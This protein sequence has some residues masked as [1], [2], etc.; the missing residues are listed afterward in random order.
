MNG[1]KIYTKLFTFF[2]SKFL[3]LLTFGIAKLAVY[4]APLWLA[5][6]LSK[7]DYGVLEYALAGLG[8]LIAASFSL[9]IPGAYPYFILRKKNFKVKHAFKIHPLWLLFLFVINQILYI[10]FEVFS[11]K[12][13]L[14][15]NFSYIIANQQFYSTKLKSKESI[16][17]AVFIDSGVYFMLLI[18]ATL[19]LL[20]IIKPTIEM[21]NKTIL[22]YAFIY[23]LYAMAQF[24]KVNKE[25]IISSYKR[26]LKFSFH[27]L[28]ASILIFAI[29]VAGRILTE[30]FLG[31]EYV[32]TY[33]FYYRLASLVVVIHQV[34]SIIFFKKIYTF[35]PKILDKY[36]SL[37]FIGIYILSILFYFISPYVVVYFSNYYNETFKENTILYFI[38]SS[39][40]VMWIAS[41]L[42]SSIIDREGIAKKN[43]LR[44]LTLIIISLLILFLLKNYLTL[45][46]LTFIHFT[47]FYIATMIQY[48]SLSK[49][50]IYFKKATIALTC[51][52]TIS[53]LVV[54]LIK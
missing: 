9:G 7:Y 16:L 36:F 21:V 20:N 46:L 53:V 47:V 3:F 38:L 43:N 8:I 29:T 17:K 6:I 4:L 52:F 42:N 54:L 40:M 11:F 27:I 23:V 48:F 34:V 25:G 39:Q 45:P 31:I 50:N 10:G 44:L 1:T 49:K 14:A 13:Y 35:E 51:S 32:G 28:I 30:Y 26:I 2:K 33:G 24:I 19:V 5:D 15:L 37:F 41:A 22:I 18:Y 12:I